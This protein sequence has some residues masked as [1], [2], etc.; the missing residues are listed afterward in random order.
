M[1]LAAKFE[2]RKIGLTYG[3]IRTHVRLRTPSGWQWT[4]SILEFELVEQLAF[5]PEVAD[6][7]TQPI[8]RYSHRGKVRRYTPDVL[9][10]LHPNTQ[11]D[12]E[13][14]LIEAK[15][16]KDISRN[17]D[18]YAVPFAAAQKWCEKHSATF[19]LLKKGTVRSP[20]LY[21]ARKLADQF[22]KVP[23]DAS[24]ALILKRLNQPATVTEVIADLTRQGVLEMNA[25][26]AVEQAVANRLVAC[27]LA[28]PFTDQSA[29]SSLSP[30]QPIDWA[31]SPI[32]RVLR[33]ESAI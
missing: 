8:I 20:Y 15:I 7:I 31:E 19:R 21:N 6:L 17:R 32:I 27:D 5:S 14:Y 2:Q 33:T 22:G 28:L 18:K 3:S 23:N 12:V 9:V 11:G 24:L 26:S 29:L 13:Y 25:R 1:C 30:R 10:E 16:E 4:E